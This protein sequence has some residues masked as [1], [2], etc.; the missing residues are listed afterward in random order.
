MEAMRK[1]LVFLFIFNFIYAHDYWLRPQKFILSKGDTLILHLYVGDK[2]KVEIER[3]FQMQMTEKFELLKSDGVLDL[4]PETQDKSIPLLRRIIDFDG[5]GLIVMER[6]W[7]YIELSLEE[8]NEY[9]KHEGI[10]DIRSKLRGKVQKERYRRYIKS[11]ILSGDKVD[12]EIYKKVVGQRLEIV[13]LQNPYL[14]KVG[15]KLEVQVLFEGKPLV[16]KVVTLY[17]VDRDSVF[18][19]KVRT[20]KNG[21]AK[22]K[23]KNLGFHLVR[24]VHLRECE[25]CDDVNWE[26]FWTSFSFEVPQR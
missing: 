8:F 19:Q 4:L 6:G 14:L 18:E 23:I 26:S 9:L 2:L 15:D 25:N 17:S 12:G 1:V 16:N 21:I 11:L 10:T 24:L 3:E 5:L 7:A 22:F 13:L 20:N